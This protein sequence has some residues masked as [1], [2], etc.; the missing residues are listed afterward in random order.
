MTIEGK[1]QIEF[2]HMETRY[3]WFEIF[4]G[5][6]AGLEIDDVEWRE[7][8]ERHLNLLKQLQAMVVDGEEYNRNL[9][10]QDVDKFHLLEGAVSQLFERAWYQRELCRMMLLNMRKVR[11]SQSQPPK[12]AT[13]LKVVS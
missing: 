11:N 13:S 12:K 4:T 1:F 2:E 8:A 3:K 5:E 6:D 9:F 7:S 10:V